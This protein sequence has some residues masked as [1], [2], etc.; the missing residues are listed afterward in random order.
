VSVCG[1]RSRFGLLVGL[2]AFFRLPNLLLSAG[3]GIFFLG[4]FLIA[5]SRETF[6][7]GLAF[8]VAFLAGIV[9]MLAANAINAGNPFATTYGDVD[10]VAPELNL[11]H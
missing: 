4:A 7:E 2:S 3:Y 8:A 11:A 5:R 6:L 1:L 9:P 10:F